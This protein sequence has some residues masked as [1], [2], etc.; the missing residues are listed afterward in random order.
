MPKL[1]SNN[2]P[3]SVQDTNTKFTLRPF[4]PKFDWR[5]ASLIIISDGKYKGKELYLKK[6]IDDKNANLKLFWQDK[7]IG[8][9]YAEFK[10]DSMINIWDVVIDESFRYQGLANLM[11]KILTRELLFR[12]TTTSFKI[13]MIKLFKREEQEIKLQNVGMAVIVH[14]LGLDCEYVLET[15]LVHRN[16]KGV[17]LITPTET[18]PPAYFLT[19]NI[20]P[21][22]LVAL[23][24]NLETD[25]P[26]KDYEFYVR[27]RTQ[28]ESFAD[29]IK[30]GVMIVG[31]AD[32]LLRDNGIREFVSYI[33]TSKTEAELFYSKINGIK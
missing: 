23:I 11:V 3:D 18:T 10:K 13:R 9:C 31:N 16:I 4:G 28:F 27:F 29:W 5:S 33:A 12:Q 1:K 7:E 19:L 21:Y 6:E 25:R 32:Y 26:I 20:F 2:F 15:I 24:M 22:N 17:S 30:K 14:K 8:H